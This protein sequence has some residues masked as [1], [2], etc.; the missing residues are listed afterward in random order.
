MLNLGW[1]P[2]QTFQLCSVDFCHLIRCNVGSEKHREGLSNPSILSMPWRIIF[3]KV[4][5]LQLVENNLVI[6]TCIPVCRRNKTVIAVQ[7]SILLGYCR[8]T[9]VL[10]NVH[11]SRWL[12]SKDFI[13][14]DERIII[15]TANLEYFSSKY[16][17][18]LIGRPCGCEQSMPGT[19]WPRLQSQIKEMTN[20]KLL[21][22]L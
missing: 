11:F 2:F 5:S 22:R 12:L 18:R 15:C 6:T 14:I 3:D 1:F 10:M 17:N 19:E 8:S 21:H 16:I 4:N 13:A 9:N 20:P 7:H